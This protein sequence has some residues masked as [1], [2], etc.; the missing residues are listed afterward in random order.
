M[1]FLIL[2]DPETKVIQAYDLWQEKKMYGK[3]YLGTVR[4]T[5]II[6]EAGIIIKVFPKA[7]PD[8]N[9]QEILTYL[10][11]NQTEQPS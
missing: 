1:P 7:K 9:A 8:T 5:Y 3:T 2:A 10:A 6:D 4:A 11:E